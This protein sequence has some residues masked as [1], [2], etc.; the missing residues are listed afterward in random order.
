MTL[1]LNSRVNN[2]SRAR[3]GATASERIDA[4]KGLNVRADFD[5]LSEAATRDISEQVRLCALGRLDPIQSKADFEHAACF[6]ESESNRVFAINTL[7][8]KAS[9]ETLESIALGRSER[10]GSYEQLLAV[11]RLDS[12]LSRNALYSIASNAKSGNVMVVR[13]LE[14]L[15]LHGSE[16]ALPEIAMNAGSLSERETALSVLDPVAQQKIYEQIAANEMVVWPLRQIAI[17]GLDAKRSGPVL[18]KIRAES[19]FSFLRRQAEKK[20]G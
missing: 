16:N 7:N 19:P 18:E 3:C 6:D 11:G 2:R 10:N 12:T 9:R 14:R 1:S 17:S 4:I 13:A 15:G 20:L 8:P 5:V